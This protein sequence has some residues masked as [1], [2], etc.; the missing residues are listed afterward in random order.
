MEAGKLVVL[1][2]ISKAGVSPVAESIKLGLVE[3][4]IAAHVIGGMDSVDMFGESLQG[5]GTFGENPLRDLKHEAAGLILRFQEEVFERLAE[6]EWVVMRHGI[7]SLEADAYA[8]GMDRELIE[9]LMGPLEEF[10][11]LNSLKGK[12]VKPVVF[13]L[14]IA[15]EKTAARLGEGNFGSEKMEIMRKKSVY[16]LEKACVR[17]GM[18]IIDA[19]RPK[20]EVSSHVLELILKDIR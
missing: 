8:L 4:G 10:I 3:R 19:D 20:E 7:L 5:Y 17:G 1:E 2:G 9:L 15:P 16:L 11:K 13:V 12:V 18:V 14:D 6:G